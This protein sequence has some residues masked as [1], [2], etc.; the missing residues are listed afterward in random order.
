MKD[1]CRC[2]GESWHITGRTGRKGKAMIRTDL[3]TSDDETGAKGRFTARNTK[4]LLAFME[5]EDINEVNA[6][7]F[8]FGQTAHRARLSLE[9]VREIVLHPERLDD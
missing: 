8:L 9:D 1:L 5:S 6:E 7:F 2:V 3:V 4:E